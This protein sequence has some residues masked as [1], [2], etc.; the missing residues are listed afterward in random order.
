MTARIFFAQ[1]GDTFRPSDAS[2]TKIHDELPSGVYVVNCDLRGLFLRQ[3]NDFVHEGKV[4][5]SSDRNAERI[6]T[7]FKARPNTTGVM[8]TG[9]KGTGKSMLAKLTSE[10]CRAE[11]FPT[12]IVNND[13]TENTDFF[14]FIQSISN[15]CLIIFDEFEKTHDK[16]AQE[17]IL[18]L[19][20]G[21][22]PSKKLFVLT[23]NYIYRVD[24][25][26]ANRPGRIFYSFDFKSLEE[27]FIIEYCRDFNVTEQYITQIV[28]LS[29]LYDSFTFDMLKAIIEE[30]ARYGES[31][32]DVL[33]VLNAKPESSSEGKFE[34]TVTLDGKEIEPTLYQRELHFNPF[35]RNSNNSIWVRVPGMTE[36]DEDGDDTEYVTVPI[37]STT[38][39]NYDSKQGVFV[40]E[41]KHKGGIL[42]AFARRKLIPASFSYLGSDFIM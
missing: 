3:I 17:R 21:V 11:G 1:N 33:T 4:Y 16:A 19:L 6:I 7:T 2:A 15:P 13:F 28:A 10:K 25:N 34:F 38:L 18:T 41:H 23:T 32:Q 22:Y 31:P 9:H 36:P 26:L 37:N 20:D 35:G 30:M 24:E 39:L 14:P 5:G 40:Y 29:K 27:E 12:I 42:R 8:L